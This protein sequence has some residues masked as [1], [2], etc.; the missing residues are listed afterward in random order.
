MI[1]WLVGIITVLIGIVAA[2]YIFIPNK[3]EISKTAFIEANSEAAYRYVSEESK[4]MQWWPGT[5]VGKSGIDGNQKGNFIYNNTRYVINNKSINAIE[6]VFTH[7]TQELNSH[8]VIV[9]LKKESTALRW[10]CVMETGTDPLSKIRRY[11]RAKEIKKNMDVI[12]SSLQRFLGKIE[13]IYNLKIQEITVLDTLLVA[14][15]M[16]TSHYPNTKEIY[17]LIKELK[18]F[19]SREGAKETNFPMLNIL[20][21]DSNHFETMVAIPV[22]MKV[23]SSGN[24]AFKR[25]VPGRILVAEVK[26]GRRSVDKAFAEMENYLK[27]YQIKS[28]AI[29]F[30]SLVTDRMNNPDSI[31]WVTRLYY[32]I[33]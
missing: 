21:S 30:E 32:P 26:G 31:N 8:I 2:I 33:L 28:P 12:F 1:K 9:P 25:M 11:K 23:K 18:Q 14:T 7:D 16:S 13:N 15:K 27:D 29:P 3:L 24:F 4:W 5:F 17:I 19:I 10:E 6:I 20:R 22:N